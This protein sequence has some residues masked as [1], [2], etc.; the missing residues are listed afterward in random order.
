MS[1]T[2]AV[3]FT[4]KIIGWD[5]VPY[6]REKKMKNIA[7]LKSFKTDPTGSGSGSECQIQ[8]AA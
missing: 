3:I 1:H 6:R 7:N 4:R 2:V 8:W 5:Q